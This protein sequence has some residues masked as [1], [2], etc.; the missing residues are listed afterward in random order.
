MLKTRQGLPA[1][2]ISL[3]LTTIL[4]APAWGD[5]DRRDKHGK[6]EKKDK[7]E[8]YEEREDHRHY[9]NR[10]SR[11]SFGDDDHARIRSYY[12]RHHVHVPPGF[13]KRGGLPPG[14]VRKGQVFEVRHHPLLLPLP[15]DLE[16]LLPPPP[17]EV[18]R[19]IIGR[20]MVLIH[21]HSHKVLDVLHDALP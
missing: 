13:A 3:L 18:I 15:H 4:A 1:L 20:D 14:L 21:K 12:S 17:H 6:H 10:G 7:K 5:D 2:C 16:R 11:D 9:S 8:K 19:R